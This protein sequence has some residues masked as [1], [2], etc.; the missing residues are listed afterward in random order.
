MGLAPHLVEPLQ[1]Q[2]DDGR[3]RGNQHLLP[4]AGVD[5]LHPLVYANE[6]KHTQETSG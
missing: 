5:L 2:R 6:H 1:M 4:G 3:Q